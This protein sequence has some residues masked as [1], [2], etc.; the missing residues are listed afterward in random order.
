M[1]KTDLKLVY[2]HYPSKVVK[3]EEYN[4]SI[5]EKASH[6]YSYIFK[7]EAIILGD[8]FNNQIDIPESEIDGLAI[9]FS[10]L[11]TIDDINKFAG[12]YGLLGISISEKNTYDPPIYGPSWFE[13]I[14][15]W[16]C[17][18]EYIRRLLL[19]YRTL[20]KI[21]KGHDVEIEGKLLKTRESCLIIRNQKLVE[22][23]WWDGVSTNHSAVF[24]IQDIDFKQFAENILI[25]TIRDNLAG[26]IKIDFSRKI[27]ANNAAIGF[28]ITP[29]HS[30]P[31]LLAA[32]YYDLWNLINDNR[33][34][35]V[36][37]YCGLPLDKKGRGKY[38]NNACKQADYRKR[39]KEV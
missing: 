17:H 15:A 28:R 22:I 37:D 13:P 36:C 26:G 25:F 7:H 23:T 34:I 31:Y 12:K 35:N 30:T 39:K 20:S 6:G 27:P 19:L 8:V 38:C 33:I 14:K 9:R 16:Y 4:F 24:G 21:K 3:P 10:K 29:Q 1:K 18:I 32:I 5:R 11:K 2:E